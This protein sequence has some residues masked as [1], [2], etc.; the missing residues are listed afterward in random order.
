MAKS[1]AK[2]LHLKVAKMWRNVSKLV[3]VK[4]IAGNGENSVEIE[5]N[6]AGISSSNA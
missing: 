2:P 3:E 6:N 5:E 4:T 1:I